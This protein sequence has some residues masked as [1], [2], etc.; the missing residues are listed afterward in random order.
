MRHDPRALVLLANASAHGGIEPRREITRRH[1]ARL[2][3][4]QARVG[5]HGGDSL[6]LGAETAGLG[7]C[8]GRSPFSRFTFGMITPD[9]TSASTSAFSTSMKLPPAAT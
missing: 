3:R 4:E 9:S 8:V 2:A 7:A 5:D 6:P 1:L